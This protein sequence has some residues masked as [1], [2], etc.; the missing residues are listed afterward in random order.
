MVLNCCSRFGYGNDLV[1]Y[2]FDRVGFLAARS[3]P[4]LEGISTFV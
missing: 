1:P 2:S 4:I 3:I